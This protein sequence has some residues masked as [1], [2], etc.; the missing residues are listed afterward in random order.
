MRLPRSLLLPAIVTAILAIAATPAMAQRMGG[1]RGGGFGG[2]FHG[3]FAGGEFHGRFADGGFRGGFHEGFRGGFHDGFRRGFYRGFRGR[4]GFGFAFGYPWFYGYGYPY[5]GYAD[6]YPAY[7]APPLPPVYSYRA[8]Y[9]A[10]RRVHRHYHRV[11]H[12][13]HCTCIS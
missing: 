2:G 5:Y 6:F 11:V 1:F 7:Y 8:V 4:F 12:R 13:R 10:P 9:Y 3:G